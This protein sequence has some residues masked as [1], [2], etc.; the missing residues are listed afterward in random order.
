MRRDACQAG[1]PWRRR[2][3][4]AP[5]DSIVLVKAHARARFFRR[6][7]IGVVG[8]VVLAGLGLAATGWLL[9]E[10]AGL[11]GPTGVGLTALALLVG[12][13]MLIAVLVM[14]RGGTSPLRAVMDAADR[15]ADGDYTVRVL[16]LIHI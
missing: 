4:G 3:A 5:P 1:P 15:V 14:V 10:R 7:V 13:F 11:G 8:L 16:S 6:V 9:A 2:G 12:T